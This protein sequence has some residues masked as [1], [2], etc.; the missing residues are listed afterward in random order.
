[1]AKSAGYSKGYRARRAANG[2]APLGRGGTYKERSD[3][4][5]SQFAAAA[6]N[7]DARR[8]IKERI[9]LLNTERNS[10]VLAGD[11]VV[12]ARRVLSQG[13]T[14]VGRRAVPLT[15]A[16]RARWQKAKK[17]AERDYKR[18]LQKLGA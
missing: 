12:R 9:E 1:M 13:T 3:R 10:V 8:A 16:E 18:G 2:G 17:K 7:P 4:L 15:Q 14:G 11:A 5:R 6:G